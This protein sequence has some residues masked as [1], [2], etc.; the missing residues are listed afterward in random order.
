M[1]SLTT[2]LLSHL[3]M[4][5]I[6]SEHQHRSIHGKRRQKHNST[7]SQKLFF[8]KFQRV[9]LAIIFLHPLHFDILRFDDFN[10]VPGGLTCRELKCAA[11]EEGSR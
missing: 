2:C 11:V 4:I 8:E 7:L 3:M 6:R 9:E 5:M 1:F 10:N